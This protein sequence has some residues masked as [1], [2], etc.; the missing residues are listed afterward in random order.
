MILAPL[1]RGFLLTDCSCLR[2]RL[3]YTARNA[4]RGGG[5]LTTDRTG[6]I[7]VTERSDR[8]E[9]QNRRLRF[10]LIAIALGFGAMFLTAAMPSNMQTVTAQKFVLVDANGKVRADLRLS[11]FGQPYFSLYDASGRLRADLGLDSGGYPDFSL[12]DASDKLRAGLGLG[13]DGEPGFY[14]SNASGK[15]EVSLFLDLDGEPNFFLQDASGTVR[16]LLALDK[17][18]QP[19]F[20]LYDA[21]SKS[22]LTL[23]SVA[24]TSPSRGGTTITPKASITAF[25]KSGNVIGRWPQ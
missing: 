15:G 2:E 1:R 19:R 14:L 9:R 21:S 6:A 17:D 12:Y 23:G 5:Y 11:T 4:R 3:G 24:L 18:G 10:G 20:E 8:L 13:T 16:T 7:A 22:R 25:D